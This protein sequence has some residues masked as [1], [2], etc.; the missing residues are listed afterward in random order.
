MTRATWHLRANSLVLA[1]LAG[2]VALTIAH[3]W[4]PAAQWLMVHVLLLGAVSTAILLWSQHFADTLLRRPAPGGPRGLTVRIGAHTAGALL[5]VAGLT[6]PNLG[7]VV[8]GA[9]LVAAVAG[10]QAV[11]IGRQLRGGF[12]TRFAPLARWYVVAGALLPV[13]VAC[14]VVLARGTMGDELHGRLYVAHV[15]ITLVGWVATTVLGTLQVLWPTVQHARIE[16]SDEAA[17]RRSLL[18]VLAGLGVIVVAVA[19][20]LR[21]LVPVGCVVIAGGAALVGASM[22]RQRRAAAPV[23]AANAARD[24]VPRTAPVHVPPVY[25]PA[26]LAASL[27]W[28]V[29]SVLAFGAVVAAAPGWDVAADRVR[30]LVA[31]FAVGFAAQVLVASLCHLLPVVLGGGPA[32]SRRT[33]AELDRGAV[34]RLVLVNG[35]LL[36]FCAPVPS[37]VRVVVSLVVLGAL[38]A[39]LVLA[40]RAVLIAGRARRT[41]VPADASSTRRPATSGAL[42][43]GVGALALAVVLGVVADPAAAGLATADASDG[44]VA[45]GRTTT[46]D[47][48]AQD[49]RF[50]PARIEVPAGDRLVIRVTNAD[51]DVHDLVVETGATSGRLAPD[52]VA[53]VDV[54]VV[55]ADLDAWCSVAGHRL[56]GMTLQIVATG[57]AV[58]AAAATSADPS[59]DPTAADEH[60]HHMDP[61]TDASTP[62]AAQD[63]D[64]MAEPDASF[65]ARDA[66]LDPLPADDG[67]VTHRITLTVQEVVREVAP[68]VTQRLWTFGG[69]APGPVLHGRV[70]DTFVVTL[71]NDGSIG[72]SIDFHAGALAPDDVMRTIAPGETLTY[73]FTATRSGIWMYH[74]S[75]MPMSVHIANGML[76]AVVIEPDGLPEVDRQFVVVQHEL[77]L[78]AQGGEVDAAKVAGE[79]PDLVVFNGYANQYRDRPLTAVAGERVRFWVLD[80]GPNRPSAFHV[81]GG[82]FDTV[83]REGDYTLRDGGSTGSGGSQVLA[84]QPAEGGFVELTFPAAGTYSFV[85]HVMSDAEKG[86]VGR[87]LVAP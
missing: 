19:T 37:T 8:A 83:F 11:V 71:V 31:P 43:V 33:A 40:V 52:E 85:T 50:S 66:A 12:P 17:G 56:M 80:A 44:V 49:M 32:V 25:A 59:A 70:G 84:L 57:D 79:V 72:H 62:S 82:Q 7:L 29:G 39:F 86:G 34:V 28:F 65:V 20:G 9:V 38:A 58:E 74:C 64:L 4:I 6:V 67:P 81:V 1:W 53:E 77:Y 15:V 87:V 63:L 36:L 42:A 22:W 3:R 41:P 45:T 54:G 35:G 75:T 69:Q 46:V 5:V 16:P 51:T 61:T 23:V 14:G 21:A 13:G 60:A 73:R 48:Q 2:A 10:T 76:G 27:T 24:F 18:V 30:G 47:V 26:A 55:G 78:G 68:G